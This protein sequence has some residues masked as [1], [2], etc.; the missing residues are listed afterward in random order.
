MAT[1]GGIRST[2]NIKTPN[3]QTTQEVL[4]QHLNTRLRLKTDLNRPQTPIYLLQKANRTES[5]LYLAIN[6]DTQVSGVALIGIVSNS[7]FKVNI[8]APS[9]GPRT[10][11]HLTRHQRHKPQLPPSR[12]PPTPRCGTRSTSQRRRAI[13]CSQ[14][15]D[16]R[17]RQEPSS[18]GP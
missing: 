7:F 15:E 8:L 3:T 5:V 6:D 10:Y 9:R 16:L 11:D 1:R 13:S 14:P 17:Y 18:S 2:G 12:P 4:R